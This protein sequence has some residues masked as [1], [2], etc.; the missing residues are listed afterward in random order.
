MIYGYARCSTN[1]SKQDINRQIKELKA[2]GADEV[3]FEYE[4][5]DA[6]T[7]K[8]LQMM[9]E[10][11]KAGDTIITLEVSRLSR[12][13]QQLCE[14]I[15]IIRQKRL[16]LMIVG[17]ITIDC[18]TGKTDPMSE[19]FLQMAG[20]F[21]QLELAMIRARV[22]SGM[23]NAKAKGKKIGRRPTTKEDIP[24]NFLKHYAIFMEGKMNV[25]ELARVCGLSRPTVY[26]YLKMIG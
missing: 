14:L 7:K 18:R 26:K 11:S 24:A 19:A 3:I 6:K 8:E 22:K 25:S 12:S 1:E 13:T 23:E 10:I 9:L 4:H 15:D 17:S 5:G 2:A 20:V 16:R 21:S